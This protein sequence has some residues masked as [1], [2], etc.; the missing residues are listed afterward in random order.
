MPE[1]QIYGVE[2]FNGRRVNC[3]QIGLGTYDTVIQYFAKHGEPSDNRDAGI[4]WLLKSVGDAVL[5]DPT[6]IAVEPVAEHVH[7]LLHLVEKSLTGVSLVQCAIGDTDWEAQLHFVPKQVREEL[8]KQKPSNEQA[9][10]DLTY[11]LNMSC[12]EREHPAMAHCLKRL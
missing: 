5:T 4:A 7:A 9:E 2:N 3:V 6:G 12:V 11:L 1:V 8:L 10:R